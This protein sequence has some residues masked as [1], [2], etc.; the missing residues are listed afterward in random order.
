[1]PGISENLP[2][3]HGGTGKNSLTANSL[4]YGNGTNNV[5][6]LASAKG[7][8]YYASA[9]SAPTVVTNLP[10]THGGTGKNSLTAN[11][12]LY[13]NGTNNVAELAS[14]KGVVYYAAAG[15][16][17]TVVTNLPVTHGGTGVNTLTANGLI[18]AHGTNNFTALTPAKGTVYYYKDENNNLV[19]GIGENLP[20]THGGTGKDTINKNSLVYGD[21]TGAL[22]EIT[23]TGNTPKGVVYYSAANTAPSI[24]SELPVSHGGTGRNTLTSN[25]IITGNNTGNVN[26]IATADGA[27]Y[28]TASNGAAKFGTLPVAQGGTGVKTITADGLIIGNGIDAV[29]ALTP[30]KGAVYYT[31]DKKPA[32]ISELPVS[33][34]GTGKNTNTA[35]SVLVGN[36]TSAI[37]NIASASGA[38]Y[39]TAANGEPVFGT[40]PV[41]QGGTGKTNI[42]KNSLVYGDNTGALKE[43][44]PTGNTPK[45]VVYYSAANTAPTII[46]ELPVTHGGSGANTLT[47]NGFILAHGTSAFT[48]LTPAKGVLYY[49]N[50]SNP[51]ITTN[52]PV[53]H[54][55]TGKNSL[56]A[57]SILYGNGTNNVAELASAKGVVYYAADGNAPTVVSELPVTHGGTGKNTHT[58]NSV[59]VGN[60][61]G[62]VKNIG[63]VSGALYSTGSGVEPKFGTLPVA[64][65]G[66]G[67]TNLDN[68]TVGQASRSTG[69]AST[70]N[71]YT[72]V[73]FSTNGTETARATD[74][75]FTYNAS[76]NTAKIGSVIIGTKA[77]WTYNST[78]QSL[79]LAFV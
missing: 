53:S 15:S 43:I 60:N 65:G 33:H 41:A 29:T 26:M 39:A 49:D 1:M 11:S 67:Q 6:E 42:N 57:N 51:G 3:S 66:T 78:T 73:W 13:G 77:Q 76:T 68:V 7:V 17:P 74:D 16:A 52:L 24:V 62:A 10:V 12:I 79:D 30:A 38:L 50:N 18:I 54:G 37:K 47:A 19:P 9:G 69:T 21:N 64:Q 34:G 44:T 5:A 46:S 48:A 27:F 4:L 14:A 40:L 72:H 70:A 28:A 31:S 59:I 20:V 35:N 55:G 71:A 2:V 32:I 22:K 61:T 63:S 56:T 8:V 58:L 25:A 23:P 36:G 45:G 75:D